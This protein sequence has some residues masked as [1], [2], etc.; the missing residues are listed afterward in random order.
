MDYK[1]IPSILTD[2]LAHFEEQAQVL[3]NFA[4]YIQ[5]DYVDG[6]F[7]PELT[8][9]EAKVIREVDIACPLEAHLMVEDPMAQ[10][11]DWYKAGA[12]R[13]IGHIEEMEDQ[14][15]FTELLSKL[16]LEVGLALS[17][18][19]PLSDLNY[20]IVGGLNVVLLMA[21]EVGVQGSPFHDE[22][23]VKIKDLRNRYPHLNIEVD[24]G[25]NEHTILK[26]KEAG[27][28]YFAVGKDILAA[29]DP[30]AEYR[31]L[32]ALITNAN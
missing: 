27:A 28:N 17:L 20:Q 3:E 6:Y 15:E 5:V 12:A 13:V 25:V 29:K 24:G 23:L 26:A 10:V 30:A 18:D 4:D 11:R 7:A 1:V 2:T 21:H 8:C 9:C 16:G 14:V 32:L 31:K 19:T 22:V